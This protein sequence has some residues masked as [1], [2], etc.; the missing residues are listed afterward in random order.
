MLEIALS[1]GDEGVLQKNIAENQ[2]ISFKYLDHI[3]TA[4]KV[5]GLVTNTRGKKSGY[6]LTRDPSEITML[7]IH[8]AFEPGICVVDCLGCYVVCE[9]E[10]I[11]V[12]RLFWKGLNDRIV[13][14]FKNTTLKDLVDKHVTMFN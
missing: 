14:Y 5:A 8:K 10:D 6:I 12:A 1:E 9:R 2:N 4:L 13:D 7:D 11:C 3:I